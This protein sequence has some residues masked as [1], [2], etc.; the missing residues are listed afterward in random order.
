MTQEHMEKAFTK[1]DSNNRVQKGVT[2]IPRQPTRE[3]QTSSMLMPCIVV[4]SRR[5]GCIC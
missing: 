4:S 5:A 2:G 1:G 3:L